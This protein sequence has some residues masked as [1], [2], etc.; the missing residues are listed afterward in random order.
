MLG[1]QA[2]TRGVHLTGTVANTQSWEIAGYFKA[3]VVTSTELPKH[4]VVS[5]RPQ[6]MVDL[7]TGRF[8][9]EI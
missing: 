9:G 8:E 2:A 6:L 7:K 1:A 4:G 3:M 5:S